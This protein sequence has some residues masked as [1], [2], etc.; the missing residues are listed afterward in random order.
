MATSNRN[1]TIGMIYGTLGVVGFSLT[2][3]ATRI[4]VAYMD[5][6]F[7]GLGRALVAALAAGMVLLVKR[8]RVPTRQEWKELL[9]VALGVIVGFPFLTA[10]AMERVPANHGAVV[11]ALLPLATAGAAM[12]LA[13]E[14]PS[15]P[16]WVS[17]GIGCVAVLV[18]AFSSGVG[19]LGWADLAL[20]GAVGSEAVGYAIGGK[21]A[22]TMEGW[23]VISWA[24]VLSFPALLIP[25]GLRFDPAVLQAPWQAWMSFLYVSLVS[26]FLAFFAWYRG[27][28]MG[29][30]AR[31]SQTQYF[32]PF[33]TLV[34]S[35][36]LLGEKI[37]VLAVIIAIVVVAAVA[38]GR[39]AAVSQTLTERTEGKNGS[40]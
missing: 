1:E 6:L 31:V 39:K 4:A 7:V 35:A 33:L 40:S 34:A 30:V 22:R 25:V 15:R 23:R 2:L 28:A 3:P 9:I 36:F 18:F 8:E 37:T 24:L 17:S 11:L 29:G 19:G 14:R 10:W 16:F 26:Q 13:G 38:K 21:L 12:L 27:L 20:A 5:P 32:Q